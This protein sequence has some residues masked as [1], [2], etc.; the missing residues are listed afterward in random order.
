MSRRPR[1]L[2]LP[3][4]SILALTFLLIPIVYTIIFSFNDSTR[5]NTVWEGFTLRHWTSVCSVPN[6][7]DALG[8]S[9]LIGVVSTLGATVLGTALAC[10]CRWLHQRSFSVQVWPVCFSTL[11]SVPV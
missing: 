10:S 2:G 3:I 4:Y 5:S 7:C 8:N 1:K 11:A 6:V 9:I